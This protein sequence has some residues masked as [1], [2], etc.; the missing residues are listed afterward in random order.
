[1]Q[2]AMAEPA[3]P[4]LLDVAARVPAAAALIAGALRGEDRKALRLAHSLLRGAVAEVVVKLVATFDDAPGGA[5]PARPPT[6]RRWHALQDLTLTGPAMM[7]DC[8]CAL[9]AEP[10]PRLMKLCIG[11]AHVTEGHELGAPAARALAAAALRMPA[12]MILELR[13]PI[14]A[15]VLEAAL[16]GEWR[17]LHTLRVYEFGGPAGA[18]AAAPSV[19]APGARHRIRGVTLRAGPEWE[20]ETEDAMARWLA[21]RG[22]PL[23]AL[24]IDFSDAESL[25]ALVAAPTLALRSLQVFCADA[26]T[27]R[28]AANARWPLESLDLFFFSTPS[29]AAFR[30]LT[31]A[32]WP[33]LTHFSAIVEVFHSDSEEDEADEEEEEEEEEE[34]A[35]LDAASFALCPKLQNLRLR[36]VVVGV[37][38]ARALASRRWAKLRHLDLMGVRLDD[39]ALA[40]LAR[41]AWPALEQLYLWY[42]AGIR[43]PPTLADVRRWAP[44]VTELEV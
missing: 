21:A 19:L 40:A 26:V 43:A 27:L 18:G 34:G 14:S 4:T 32:A 31:G 11:T 36:R 44:A 38:C 1:M 33:E 37:A 7:M 8:L 28:A 2:P 41:G 39:D 5:L 6:A 17:A 29:A 10:W 9:G 25:A 42:N 23:E 24:S 35:T 16:R 15:A 12:L 13:V 3:Q 22:W 20:W 30:A